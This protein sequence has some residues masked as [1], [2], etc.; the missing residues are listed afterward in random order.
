MSYIFFQSPLSGSYYPWKRGHTFLGNRV[1]VYIIS[2]VTY[3]IL[4]DPVTI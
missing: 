3:T 1:I 4:T 2:K